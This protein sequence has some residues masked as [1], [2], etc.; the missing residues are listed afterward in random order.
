LWPLCSPD[1]NPCDFY[2]CGHAEKEVYVNNLHSL[3]E[4]Q[5]NIRHEIFAIPVQQLQRV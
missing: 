3:E 1:L 2:L 5:K 4:L